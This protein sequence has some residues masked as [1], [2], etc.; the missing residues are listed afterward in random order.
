MTTHNTMSYLFQC[1]ILHVWLLACCGAVAGFI[2]QQCC[3]LAGVRTLACRTLA[4]CVRT[5]ACIH[6]L[7][8]PSVLPRTRSSA[9][10]QSY[11]LRCICRVAGLA[12][13]LHV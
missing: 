7:P 6:G 3:C 1:A 4:L 11:V 8:Y 5:P 2:R 12:G 9:R 13:C 10:W